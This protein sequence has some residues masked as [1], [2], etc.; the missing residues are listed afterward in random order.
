[1]ASDSKDIWIK[2]GYKDFAIKGFRELKIERLSIAVEKNK[3]SFYHHFADLEIFIDLLLKHHIEQARIMADKERNAQNI[4]PEL[5]HI[6]AE[7]RIDLLFNR[8]LR[9][10]KNISKFAKTLDIS[11]ELTGNGFIQVW[12]KDSPL[13]LT[14]PQIE[15]LFSLALENFF[16]QIHQDNIS[17]EWLQD[18]FAELKKLTSSFG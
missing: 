9:I 6:L 13:N 3:S 16:L 10:N 1:M 7:H 14:Q 18:Y 11:N 15:G 8:Q 5:V 4:D 2:A 12:M 17:V